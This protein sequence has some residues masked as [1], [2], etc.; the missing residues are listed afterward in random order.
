M[1]KKFTIPHEKFKF[2]REVFKKGNVLYKELSKESLQFA[3]YEPKGKGKKSYKVIFDDGYSMEI[4]HTREQSYEH[5]VG[6]TQLFQYKYIEPYLE[7]GNVV[8]D[9]ACGTGYGAKWLNDHNVVVYGVDKSSEAIE[10][11]THRYPD[12]QF[13]QSLAEN[14]PF[15]DAFFDIILSVETIEHISDDISFLKEVH[16][17]LKPGGKILLTTP[18]HGFGNPFHVREYYRDEFVEVLSRWFDIDK[19]IWI[20]DDERWMELICI[21]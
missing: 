21:K 19:W 18:H 12:I 1:R 16:R 3:L 14:L 7:P 15:P 8:L 20:T 6:P 17:V 2:R 5:I 4:T 13:I 11:A 9:V 10:Y